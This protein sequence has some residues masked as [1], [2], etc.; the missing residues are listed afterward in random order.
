[1]PRVKVPINTQALVLFKANHMCSVCNDSSKKVIIHHID[2]NSSNNNVENL[3]V[4]CLQHHAEIESKSTVSKGFSIEEVKRYKNDW[5][6]RVTNRRIAFE[7]PEKIRLIR[8]DGSDTDTVYLE[9]NPGELRSFQD[10]LTFELFGFNWGNVDVYP[11]SERDVFSFLDPLTRIDR[12][13]KIRL[14]FSNG[15]L[16]NEVY[17]IWEDGKKH[18]IPDPETLKEIGGS[19]VDAIDL[20]EFNTYP[21]GQPIKDIFSV[22]TYRMMNNAMANELKK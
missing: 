3:I 20:E 18:H 7:L 6:Q 1:M 2:G 17:V 10:P 5:E 8:F 19:V 16:A 22:R 21:H 11:D 4:I 14:Q 15:S 9:E 13:R 12:C